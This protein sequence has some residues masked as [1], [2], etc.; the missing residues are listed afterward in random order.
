MRSFSLVLLGQFGLLDRSSG[1]RIPVTSRKARALL[2][3]LVMAPRCTADRATLAALLWGESGDDQARQSLRQSLSSLRRIQVNGDGLL[4]SDDETVRLACELVDA[5]CL[6][7]LQ[8]PDD[9]DTPDLMRVCASYQGAFGVGL[10]SV[11]PAFDDWLRGER[12]RVMDRAIVLH[13][14]LVK[15]LE[16]DGQQQEALVAANA[17]LAINPIREET[18]RLIIALEAVVSGRAAAMQR[19]EAFRILL[20]DELAVRPEPAT[21]KLIDGLRD[22]PGAEPATDDEAFRPSGAEAPQA[23]RVAPRVSRRGVVLTVGGLLTLFIAAVIWVW[24]GDRSIDDR[25]YGRMSVSLAPIRGGSDPRSQDL[26]RALASEAS[27]AFSRNNRVTLIEFIDT[28]SRRPDYRI[29]SQLVSSG[30]A[31]RIDVNLTAAGTNETI[32]SGSIPVN[33]GPATGFARELYGYV[34]SEIVLHQARLLAQTSSVPA[35]LWRA[36]AAK[37]QTRLGVEDPTAIASYKEILAEDPTNVIA[38]LELSDCLILRVARNQSPQRAQDIAAISDLLI[39]VKP[40]VPNSSDIAFK[41]GMLNK[42]QGNFQQA[43]SN[44]EQSVRLDPAHWNAA[45]QY[46]H[47]MMFLGRLQEG[48]RLMQEATPNLLPD[49]G[50]AETA[51]IAGETALVTD[52]YPEAAQYLGMAVTGNPTVGRIQALYAVALFRANRLDEARAAAEKARQL[53][54]NYTPESL[55]QRGGRTADARYVEA[56]NQMVEAFRAVRALK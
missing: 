3:Y 29:S 25:R 8:L 38:L 54:P 44:F 33:A 39:R 6:N 17:L 26:I 15:A 30:Q 35:K 9:A 32:W 1:A 50:A 7:L 24:P 20:R 2:A 36:R 14:R 37:L 4:Q 23:G 31:M 56:R 22:L 18:H 47:I 21:L 10:E 19:F 48:Y 11:E 52:H 40:L 12:Q 34:T 5:D 13:D 27:L 53:S 28:S 55:G 46:A 41:E 42:L 16:R 49:L 45:A 43:L 51:Y